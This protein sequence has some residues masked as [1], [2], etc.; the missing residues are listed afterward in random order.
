MRFSSREQ[1][2]GDSIRRQSSDRDEWLKRNKLSLD[3][4][5]TLRDESK[6]A[7]R[8]KHRTD[9]KT[10]LAGFLAAVESGDVPEGSFLVVESLDRLTRED[11][12]EALYLLLG[13]T[14]RGIRIVQLKPVEMIYDRS[15]ESHQ[16]MMMIMELGRGNSESVVKSDRVGKAWER[17]RVKAG[18]KGTPLTKAVPAWL[19]V[20]GD[21]FEV[22]PE[23]AQAV[24]LVYQ[25]ATDGM[26]YGQVAKKL[27]AEK[28][29]PIG[30]R[31]KFW[32][33]SYVVKLLN[34]RSVI[35]EFQPFKGSSGNRAK[36]GEPL[37]EYFPAILSEEEFLAAQGAKALRKKS[38]GRSSEWVNLFT[39]L[40]KDARDGSGIIARPADKGRRA[41]VSVSSQ[42]GSI[43]ARNFYVHVFERAVVSKLAEV[44]PRDLLPKT[45]GI[46]RVL[47]L[48]AE[49]DAAQGR[50]D[51]LKK[52]LDTE[53]DED[54]LKDVQEKLKEWRKKLNKANA[55]LNAE[56]MKAASPLSESWGSAKPL[57]ETLDEAPN[58]NEVR[59]RLR[60][61]LRRIIEVI[62][63][64]VI[65]VKHGHRL[66][67]VQVNF[68]G[69]ATRF[70]VIEF[71]GSW[72]DGKNS[73]AEEWHVTSH[74]N[75]IPAE[76]D[77]SKPTGVKAAERF[78][79]MIH[80]IG[81]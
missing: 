10:A 38:G 58:P 78:V 1:A 37:K 68:N 77:L 45:E 19:S 39:G 50:I 53:E 16:I 5:L 47:S 63:V 54:G 69:G 22:R 40:L 31:A 4:T 32:E 25:W 11:I 35:G 59:T 9:D 67:F 7:F 24:R 44:N 6:S 43:E 61:L 26:G 49:R 30:K 15:S 18:E 27:N 72:S 12:Q 80:K 17:R 65:P 81:A 33:K 23:A 75:G 76:L 74:T 2:K 41:Y 8:G 66:C 60:G 29:L 73:R 20:K 64:H 3:N 55:D 62:W 52:L 48:T 13:L 28:V 34:N 46:D 21:K 14:R 56:R 79:Q 51:K 70:Y 36:H 71:W 57:L 42:S